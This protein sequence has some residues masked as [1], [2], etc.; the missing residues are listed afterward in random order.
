MEHFLPDQILPLGDVVAV[1]TKS[2]S[3]FIFDA[4]STNF[5]KTFDVYPMTRNLITGEF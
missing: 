4:E 3:V 2:S 1:S 5:V